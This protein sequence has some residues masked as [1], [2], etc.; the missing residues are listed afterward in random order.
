MNNLQQ[1]RDNYFRIFSAK[2]D[3]RFAED[4]TCKI[5]LCS[6]DPVGLDIQPYGVSVPA[7]QPEMLCLR[8]PFSGVG[9]GFTF[10]DQFFAQQL[11]NQT[12]CRGNT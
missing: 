10:N 8:S 7:V 5:Q 2:G 1:I 11:F 6:V 9:I 3:G 12:F 4:F